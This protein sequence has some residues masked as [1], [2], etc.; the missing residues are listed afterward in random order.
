MHD[1]RAS[2]ARANERVHIHNERDFRQAKLDSEI[3]ARFLLN[4]HDKI[5]FYCIITVHILSSFI[6]KKNK[7]NNLK[8]KKI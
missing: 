5:Y 1:F 3:N 4:E 6:L 2:L 7:K 8:V